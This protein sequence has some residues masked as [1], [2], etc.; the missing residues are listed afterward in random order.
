MH[1]PAQVE[2]Q[3]DWSQL[4]YSETFGPITA[5]GSPAQRTTRKKGPHNGIN[6][7]II[8]SIFLLTKQVLLKKIVIIVGKLTRNRVLQDETGLCRAPRDKN[9]AKKISSL[10]GVGMGQHKIMWGGSED[11]ILRTRSAPLPSL[12]VG[13]KPQIS[14]STIRGLTN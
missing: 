11:P 12:D 3:L 10:C 8:S 14:Y 5:E 4:P 7:F 1:K 6:L 9:G 13:T 2:L